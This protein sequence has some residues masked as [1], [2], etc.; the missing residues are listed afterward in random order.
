MLWLMLLRPGELK[1]AQKVKFWKIQLGDDLGVKLTH[2]FVAW[3]LLFLAPLVNLSD[4]SLLCKCPIFALERGHSCSASLFEHNA[5]AQP[6]TPPVT[7]TKTACARHMGR[8]TDGNH[9][10]GILSDKCKYV[11]VFR[12]TESGVGF[13]QF[14]CQKISVLSWVQAQ[15][16]TKRYKNLG[17]RSN[18]AFCGNGKTRISEAHII[19]P[20]VYVLGV[21]CERCRNGFLFQ[22]RW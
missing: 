11:G 1:W 9:N 4:K 3:P 17:P 12:K 13:P 20:L 6:P 22:A 7:L 19:L 5:I 21:H 15:G 2:M 8:F 10:Y 16:F 18:G 14:I